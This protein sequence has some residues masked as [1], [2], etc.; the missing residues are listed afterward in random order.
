MDILGGGG[1]KAIDPCLH[2]EVWQCILSLMLVQNT[3]FINTG[4]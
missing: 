3:T 4:L 1:E 2:Q